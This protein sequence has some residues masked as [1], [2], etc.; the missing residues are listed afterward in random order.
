MTAPSL[1]PASSDL[2]VNAANSLIHLYR[3]EV[4]LMTAYRIRLDTT[5]NWAVITTAGLTGYAF[6]P[7]GN[8]AAMLFA[9]LANYFFLHVE[10]RRF[11]DFE[12]SHL[13][14]RLMERFFYP[15]VL[16][17]QTDTAWRPYLLADLVKPHLPLDRLEAIGWRLR[18]NYLWIYAAV[19]IAWLVKLDLGRGLWAADGPLPLLRL[20][21]V[22]FVPG[23]AVFAFVIVFYGWLLLLAWRA[24]SYPLEMD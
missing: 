21:R 3:A 12:V 19:L 14:V 10:A 23:A 4:N 8:Q 9:M 13:R 6:S 22:E 17:A 2:P 11:R 18:H 16:G 24:R 5:T 7:Q 20:A 15:T 1:N